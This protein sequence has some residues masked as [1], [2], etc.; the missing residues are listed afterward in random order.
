ME[1]CNGR[2]REVLATRRCRSGEHLAETLRRSVDVYNGYLPQRALGHVGPV[3]ALT[4]WQLKPPELFVAEIN[5]L[6]GLDTYLYDDIIFND[7]NIYSYDLALV[8]KSPLA[9]V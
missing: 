7:I 8:H 2:I 3:A 9:A 5:N 6:P 4:Q 1:R